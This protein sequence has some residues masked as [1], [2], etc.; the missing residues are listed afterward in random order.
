VTT[1]RTP[2]ATPTRAINPK[3]M[4]TTASGLT[5]RPPSSASRSA[6]VGLSTTGSATTGSATTGSATAAI[7]SAGT[8]PLCSAPTGSASSASA[9]ATTRSSSAGVACGGT[10]PAGT[11]PVRAALS[12]VSSTAWVGAA[13]AVSA[14]AAC[15][16]ASSVPAR[17]A[18][19]GSPGSSSFTPVG[20]TIGPPS[21]AVSAMAS[22]LCRRSGRTAHDQEQRC[23]LSRLLPTYSITTHRAKSHPGCPA[24]QRRS[25]SAAATARTP[26]R[27]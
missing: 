19:T 3:M 21:R 15:S 10:T 16:S 8:V 18:F 13:S 22:P 17:P 24:G 9:S 11:T 6:S 27:Q 23:A 5:S 12:P 14:S 26:R 7:G 1:A 2:T 20:A 25:T 4:P